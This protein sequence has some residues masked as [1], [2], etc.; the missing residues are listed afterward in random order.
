MDRSIDEPFDPLRVG[1]TALTAQR[2]L[3]FI[4]RYFSPDLS[5]TSQMLTDLVRSLGTDRFELYVI[6]SGQLYG[7]PRARLAARERFGGATIRRCWTA[8][9]GR[10]RL[11][12]RAL[13]YLTFFVSSTLAALRL[14]R[15]GDVVVAMTDPPLISVAAAVVTRLRGARLINWL[16]DIFPET[17]VAL[18]ATRLPR[19]AFGM[20]LMARNW[21]LRVAEKNV[22]LGTGM[23]RL[24]GQLQIPHAKLQVIENW[25]DPDVLASK[26]RHASN[27]RRDLGADTQFVVQYSGNM[28]RAHD[29]DTLLR[30]AQELRDERGCLFLFTGGGAHMQRLQHLAEQSRLHNMRFLPY[31]TRERLGDSL[32]AADVHVSCLLPALEG[33][34]VPSKLYGILA[35]GRPVIIIGDPDGEQARLVR[36]A[37]CGSVVACGDSA[38]LVDELRRMRADP[39]WLLEASSNARH[40]FERRYTLATAV[41]RWRRVLDSIAV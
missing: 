17:A 40:L 35:A 1:D 39:D 4:N 14:A 37:G 26:P 29:F 24:I 15:R 23:Q 36:A 28:G 30:A 12:G 25:A 7:D 18:K 34:V 32:A 5:A 2:R 16:Q 13:D 6:C 3:I 21:S 11:S 41:R 31:Q 20:L 8:R 27:L 22:V 9:F 19:W 10:D 38:G 33:L